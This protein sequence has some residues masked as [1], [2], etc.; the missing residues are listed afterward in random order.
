MTIERPAILLGL[1]LVVPAIVLQIRAYLA[2][3]EEIVRLGVQWP[4]EQVARLYAVKWFFSALAFDLFL[5]FAV[6]S[7]ADITWGERS[8]EEDRAGLDVVVAVDVSRSMLAADADPTRLG[9]SLGVIR[10]VGRQLPAVRMAVVAF[11]GEAI[12]LMPLTEDANA[13][14]IVFDG[15]GPAL[16]SAPGTNVEAGLSEALRSF[17]EAAFAHRAIV[18]FSDGEALSGNPDE[19]V[20]ALRRRGVPVLAVLAGSEEGAPVP[21]GDGSALLDDDGRPVVSKANAGLLTDIA[22]RTDGEV[23]RLADAEIVTE[24]ERRLSGFA[25]LREREGFR[26]VPVRRYRLFLGAALVALLVS[27]AVRVVRWRGMF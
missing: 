16:I 9:R 11:K 8:V 10:A 25:E 2:G 22:R 4:R 23:L 5:V 27:M 6:L 15:I 12:T 14:E 21:G 17:P 3:R 19:P 24:L 1:V 20:G 13:L 18:L 7:A 26:L